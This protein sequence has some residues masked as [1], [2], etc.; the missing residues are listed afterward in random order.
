MINGSTNIVAYIVFYGVLGMMLFTFGCMVAGYTILIRQARRSPDRARLMKLIYSSV[1]DP[2]LDQRGRSLIV[3]GAG[4][5][6]CIG[7]F[8]LCLSLVWVASFK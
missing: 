8:L 1:H 7:A 5:G 3:L 2:E 4:I 6:V